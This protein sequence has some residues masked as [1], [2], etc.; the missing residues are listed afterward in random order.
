[1]HVARSSTIDR[2]ETPVTII[3]PNKGTKQFSGKRK[4]VSFAAERTM[5]VL[6]ADAA[7]ILPRRINRARIIS[8]AISFKS[9]LPSYVISAFSA[10]RRPACNKIHFTR[11]FLARCPRKNR[12]KS[13]ASADNYFSLVT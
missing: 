7:K 12:R 1:V 6:F 2:A 11:L 4:T 8:P 5:P 9:T 10:P 13:R 3:S